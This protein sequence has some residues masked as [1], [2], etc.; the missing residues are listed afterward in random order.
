M[1]EK[2]KDPKVM[3]YLCVHKDHRRSKDHKKLITYRK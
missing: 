1:T 2:R 3:S